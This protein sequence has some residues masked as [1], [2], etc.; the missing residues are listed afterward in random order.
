MQTKVYSDNKQPLLYMPW[1][2]AFMVTRHTSKLDWKEHKSFY[3]AAKKVR[4]T[5]RKFES[6]VDNAEQ[7]TF[8]LLVQDV[9][10]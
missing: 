6:S 7:C 10:K 3:L 1:F 2:Q 4:Q 8:S 5:A 9:D